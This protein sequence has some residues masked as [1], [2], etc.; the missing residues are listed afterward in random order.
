MNDEKEQALLD[1]TPAGTPGTL[2]AIAKGVAYLVRDADFVTG[3]VIAIDGGQSI[4]WAC[5]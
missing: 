3:Q 4:A 5:L 1:R 2:E